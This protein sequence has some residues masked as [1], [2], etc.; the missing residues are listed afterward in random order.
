MVMTR[1]DSTPAS[2]KA[3]TIVVPDSRIEIGAPV[4]S[5]ATFSTALLNSVSEVFVPDVSFG[6][7]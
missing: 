1:N 4:A 2:M 5:G 7:I 6:K 3:F